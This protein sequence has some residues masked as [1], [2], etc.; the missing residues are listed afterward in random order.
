LGGQPALVGAR[1]GVA[2]PQRVQP[3]NARRVLI[4]DDNV[5]AALSLSLLLMSLGHESRVVHDGTSALK[6][7]AEFRP[8]TILLDIG[9]PDLDGYE[10]ARRLTALKK[11]RPFQIIA[12]T[13]WGHEADRVKSREAGFDLH[14]VKPVELDDLSRAL[15]GRSSGTTLH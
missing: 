15:S 8:D 5:D 6:A 1:P 7:A 12:V 10:V 11:E 14:L 4:V 2:A 13:G 9:L 3:V